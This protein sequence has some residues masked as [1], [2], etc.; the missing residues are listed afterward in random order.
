MRSGRGT[1]A[2]IAKLNTYVYADLPTRRSRIHRDSCRFYRNRKEQTLDVNYWHGPYVT[3]ADAAE[4]SRSDPDTRWDAA[5]CSHC[6]G[7]VSTAE[8][9]PIVS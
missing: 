6:L 2:I 3:V 7:S 1:H 5:P 4:A 8:A 9:R